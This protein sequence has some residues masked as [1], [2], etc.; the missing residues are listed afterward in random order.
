[1]DKGR[2]DAP[3]HT[4]TGERDLLAKRV[5]NKIDGM[6]QLEEGP[7]SMIFTERRPPRLEERLGGNHED[8]HWAQL[9]IVERPHR[10][11]NVSLTRGAS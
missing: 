8:F 4:K 9:E 2:T 11:V 10:K 5:G 7:N 1:M 3:E 6:S